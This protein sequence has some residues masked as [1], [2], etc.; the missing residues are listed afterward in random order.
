MIIICVD[1]RLACLFVQIKKTA[2]DQEYGIK[3]PTWIRLYIYY[4]LEDSKV[5]HTLH[6]GSKATTIYMFLNTQEDKL[7]DFI[8][9]LTTRIHTLTDHETLC[10]SMFT[11]PALFYSSLFS[12]LYMHCVYHRMLMTM[13]KKLRKK[14]IPKPSN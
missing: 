7:T 14:I 2:V 3:Q 9:S 8:H 1:L 11:P 5:L 12:V 6:R 13:L 4:Y 10:F